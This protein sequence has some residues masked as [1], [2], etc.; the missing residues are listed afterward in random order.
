MLAD[1]CAPVLVL[2]AVL[3]GNT[4]IDVPVGPTGDSPALEFPPQAQ[5]RRALLN[6]L[7]DDFLRSDL[8]NIDYEAHSK[9]EVSID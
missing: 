1:A 7:D 6:L 2:P 5:Q 8:T 3:A 4:H 9:A